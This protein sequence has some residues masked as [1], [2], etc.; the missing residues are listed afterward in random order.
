M[1]ETKGLTDGE[2][3]KLKQQTARATKQALES[4]DKT[5]TQVADEVDVSVR[6][7]YRWEYGDYVISPTNARKMADV[8][9]TS[10]AMF[11]PDLWAE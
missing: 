4:C 5:K 9:G 3:D 1:P 2:K 11:R 8:T 10:R 6:T 7:I